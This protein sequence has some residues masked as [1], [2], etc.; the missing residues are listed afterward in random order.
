MPSRRRNKRRTAP[1]DEIVSSFTLGD[2]VQGLLTGMGV[3]TNHEDALQAWERYRAVTWRQRIR[4]DPPCAARRY[5]GITTALLDYHPIGR[6]TWDSDVAKG[7]L[8]ADVAAVEAFR[9]ANPHAAAEIEPELDA[10]LR[11][12]EALL[13][14]AEE[15]KTLSDVRTAWSNY[16]VVRE[17]ELR[18]AS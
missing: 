7:S 1:L 16:T 15:C 2:G 11:D 8:A 9:E 14:A 10:Y 18:A 3:F 13:A 5:D 12:L 17:A 6:S 4:I